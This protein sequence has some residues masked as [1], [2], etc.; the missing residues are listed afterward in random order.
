MATPLPVVVAD[1]DA[2]ISLKALEAV[3]RDAE[4]DMRRR[5]DDDAGAPPSSKRARV[6][7]DDDDTAAAADGNDQADGAKRPSSHD[8]TYHELARFGY[9]AVDQLYGADGP[10]ADVAASV[11]VTCDLRHEKSAI[12]EAERLL[13]HQRMTP[14]K[15]ACRGVAM[16]LVPRQ[17]RS[18]EEEAATITTTTT[19]TT[20]AASLAAAERALASAG[21]GACPRPRFCCR[22]QP[23]GAKCSAVDP[24]AVAR[25]AKRVCDEA[26]AAAWARADEAATTKFSVVFKARHDGGSGGGDGGTSLR[27]SIVRAVAAAM[28][29]ACSGA[30]GGGSGKAAV[31]LKR[32][33]V[34]LLADVL[35]VAARPREP[36]L[37]LSAVPARLCSLG[38]KTHFLPVGGAAAA[39]G[40]GGGGGGGSKGGGGGGNGG[41]PAPSSPPPP[42]PND[43]TT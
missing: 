5:L 25:A 22:I 18:T 31:D 36:L 4:T 15:L 20:S 10:G 33:D 12:R 8:D 17:Q 37:L 19:T 7:V 13:G 30:G 9:A 1:D 29:A 39:G 23:V 24:A 43:A 3:K 40:G 41:G 26:A 27:D 34:V 11:L 35:P 28:E 2:P 6:V 14:V 21:S 42:P 38:G 32:P 16:L